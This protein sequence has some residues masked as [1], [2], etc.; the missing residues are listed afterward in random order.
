[1]TNQT[2][3]P[4]M[5]ANWKMYKTIPEAC[6]FVLDFLPLVQDTANEVVIC[7]PATAIAVLESVLSE[8]NIAL[9]AQN[10]YPKPEGAFTG[11][12]SPQ[13][14]LDAGATYCI[15]GHSERRG[16]F[17]ETDVLVAEKTQAALNAGLMPIVCIGES[18]EQRESG[19]T[20]AVLR[21]SLIASLAGVEPTA[22]LVIAYEPIW[23]IG[24]GKVAT[25]QDAEEAIAYIRSVL[26]EIW[27]ETA[28]TVRILYGG[29]VKPENIAEIIA[30]PNIDG[31]LVGGAS[32][33]A[34]SFALIA[35][36]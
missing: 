26:S 27:G 30:C 32:L 28:Q 9:G 35:N 15:L 16:Y 18:L 25:P 8:T 11:E 12:L 13:M 33:A 14:L 4:L 2:R 7:P 22:Q 17:A 3:R 20:L 34:E 6:E 21:E 19:Q 23:A 36:S 31:A 1:M 5:V 10:L 24:T 29:S